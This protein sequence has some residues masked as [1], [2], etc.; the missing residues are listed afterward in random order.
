VT[1]RDNV[2][3]LAL[4]QGTT[5]TRAIAYGLEGRELARHQIEL[6]QYYPKPGRVE[7]D[8]EEI[9]LASLTVLTTV[10][11]GLLERG[12]T[13]AAL[14]IT[15]QRETT[16]LW[17]RKTGKPVAKA[18]VWQDRRTADQCQALKEKGLEPA[19]TEKTGLLLDP[20]FSASKL[21][22]LLENDPDLRAR[23]EAGDLA[24]GTVDSYL[25]Y[26][27]TGVH[28]SDATNASRTMLYDIHKGA[29]D[30]DLLQTFKVPKFLLPEVIDNAFAPI[31]VRKGLLPC[32]IGVS[33]MIG[34]QQAAAVGQGCI[35]PGSIK[36][37][38]GTGC[39][40]L[41]NTGGVAPVSKNRL[42]TTVAYQLNGHVSYALEGSIF[43]A[44]AVVQWLRDGLGIIEHAEHTEGM[45]A[46]LGHNIGVYLVPAFTGLG[47]PHWDPEARGAILG[48]TRKTGP[49]HIVRAALESVAYQSHDLFEAFAAD[50]GKRPEVVRVDGGMAANS[51]LMQ[52]LSDILDTPVERPKV[53]ETTALGATF[54]AGLGAGVYKNLAEIKSF[55]HLD[56]RFDPVMEANKRQ[57]LLA[58]WQEALARV[59]L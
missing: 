26:R 57:D 12:L 44:G 13:P 11:D 51:W 47:A 54:L 30:D 25:L 29:W 15:N 1:S 17:D 41:E 46:A 22:W 8:A 55:W 20:Y 9:W 28:G 16:V 59:K 23:A 14:G 31:P 58:G 40:V 18:I 6:K 56:K 38:Y 50:S 49:E 5:S 36:S 37:T 42:L 27:L 43:I 35:A 34:D 53:I 10:V 7:H 3:L 19:I 45:A 24:F 52:F 32:A 4:D 48:L 33:A 2:Y 21:S 39:F